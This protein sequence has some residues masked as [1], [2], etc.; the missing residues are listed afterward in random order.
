ME[1]LYL[2]C[3]ANSTVASHAEGVAHQAAAVRGGEGGGDGD[4][5]PNE[6]STSRTLCLATK[7]GTLVDFLDEF[8]AQ[9]A[10]HAEHQNIVSTEHRA[11]I[12]YDRN[13]RPRIVKRDI[14]FSKNGTIKNKR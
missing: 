2:H 7:R 12:N 10:K 9:S 14:D 6:S 13:V 3:K 1:L 4:Y 5:N 8:E 11:Q